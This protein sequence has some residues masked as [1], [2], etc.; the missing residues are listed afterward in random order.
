MVLSSMSDDQPHRNK[1]LITMKIN[2]A[3]MEEVEDKSMAM[4]VDIMY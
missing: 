3:R 4:K 2:D 1:T